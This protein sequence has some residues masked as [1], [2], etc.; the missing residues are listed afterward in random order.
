MQKG[1]PQN[2]LPNWA[3]VILFVLGKLF[4]CWHVWS[5]VTVEDYRTVIT[6]VI[7]IAF[8]QCNTILM[9]SV[10]RILGTD[11]FTNLAPR[12]RGKYIMSSC[13]QSLIFAIWIQRMCL[14]FLQSYMY[15][16][17]LAFVNKWQSKVFVIRKE[18]F[19]A[20]QIHSYLWLF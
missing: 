1:W 18:C 8:L 3:N 11:L 5:R 13:T 15:F 19:V 9:Q 6:M 14:W 7:I 20:R 2:F 16:D 10:P 17:S 12:R 4:T